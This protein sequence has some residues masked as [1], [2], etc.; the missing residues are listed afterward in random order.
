M[1]LQ[2]LGVIVHQC[3]SAKDFTMVFMSVDMSDVTP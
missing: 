1:Q 3:V 2:L